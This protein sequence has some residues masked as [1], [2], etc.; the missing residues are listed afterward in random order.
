MPTSINFF[1]EAT[2]L[3]EQLIAW[4]RD[5]HQ[6]PEIGLETPNTS[7]YIQ[8][9]LT[10]LGIPFHTIIN[11]SGVV[12]TI[13]EGEPCLML[14]SD[15]DGLPMAEESGEE[16]ASINGNMHACGHD[17]HA[18]TL[19][20]AAHILKAHESE[21][22]GTV[23][24]FFQP[25]EEGYNGSDEAIAEGVLEN[26]HVDRAFAMHVVSTVPTGVIVYGE[27]PMAAAYNWKI[28]VEGV[29]G[30]G[31]MPD[32]C[33]DPITAAA[34][35]HIGLQ[36]ILAREISPMSELVITCG[37][38]NAGDAGN[39][40]PQSATMQGTIRVFDK[41]TRSSPKNASPKSQAESHK[42]TA[43]QP[44]RPSAARALRCSTTKNSWNNASNTPSRR[45]PKRNSTAAHT[46]WAPKTSAASLKP[47]PQT[48]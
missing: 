31:S 13:G 41:K 19:L 7:A 17:M 24:L 48:T 46:A 37:A 18:A 44:R 3:K 43:A 5:I 4:R 32:S 2:A 15:I 45:F 1:E 35:I 36:E 8:S 38:F 27:R 21:L 33:V 6:M 39:A 26:P 40:I 11:G 30:H 14:R 10:K 22:K 28:V 9:E 12:G 25:G 47:A 42:P 23:K 16:F 20:G 34:H 29:A